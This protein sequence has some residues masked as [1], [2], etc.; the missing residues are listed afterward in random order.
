MQNLFLF[1]RDIQL[2]YHERTIKRKLSSNSIMKKGIMQEQTI[3]L[4]RCN[5]N[6]G[7]FLEERK[8]ENGRK[9]AVFA[10]EGKL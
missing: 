5:Q 9:N 7:L 10:D 8:S 3:Y 4:L 1:T 6:S 2:S